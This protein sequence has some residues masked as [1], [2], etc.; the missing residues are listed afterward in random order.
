MNDV[1]RRM[2]LERVL[3]EAI[4]LAERCRD[5]DIAD[6][7]LAIKCRAIRRRAEAEAAHPDKAN[8]LCIE[9]VQ[10]TAARDVLKRSP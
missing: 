9:K 8:G 2:H 4:Q 3:T 6:E 7:L 10:L 1:D 5:G